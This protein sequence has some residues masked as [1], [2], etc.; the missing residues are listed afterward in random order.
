MEL[1]S[2]LLVKLLPL[3]LYMLF[4]YIIGKALNVKKGDIANLLV[5]LLLPIITFHGAYT[6][7]VSVQTMSLPLFFFVLCTLITILFLWIGKKLWKDNTGNL[8]S[9]AAGYGNYGYF[10]LPASIVLFGKEAES[11]VIIAGVGYTLYT[12]TVGYFVT[13]L[14]NFSARTSI[15]KTLM[16]PSIYTLILGLIFNIGGWKLTT[17]SGI[18]FLQVYTDFMR[19]MRGTYSALGMMLVGIAI[20]EVKHFKVDWKFTAVASLAHF[21]IW[22]L[23]M[24][25]Y[26]FIDVSFLHFYPVLI[27]KILFLFSL[28][29]VGVNLIAYATQLGVQ[30]EKGAITILVTTVFGMLYIPLMMSLFLAFF[31][32]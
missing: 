26:I 4:G 12:S 31:N 28:I 30:P 20:A 3:Y 7:P 8:L 19:D 6:T 13:A 2:G 16:L 27:L 17:G 1:F 15:W 14:G 24:I 21:V 32:N 23:V 25:S 5:F 22:P 10:A 11:L 9:F 29:P 18:D